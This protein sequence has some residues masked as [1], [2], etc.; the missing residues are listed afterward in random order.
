MGAFTT[1]RLGDGIAHS[2]LAVDAP[3]S[4]CAS[5]VTICA[6]RRRNTERNRRLLA[7]ALGLI[8]VAALIIS[9]VASA[10]FVIR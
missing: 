5:R 3:P 2:V 10:V 7:S 1:R 9:M 8:V 6:V 4:Q